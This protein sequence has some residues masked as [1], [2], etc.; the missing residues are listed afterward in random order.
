MTCLEF[1]HSQRLQGIVDVKFVGDKVELAMS[2][3][4]KTSLD[5]K[6]ALLG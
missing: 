4:R 2:S 1:S 6:F 3:H 5:R